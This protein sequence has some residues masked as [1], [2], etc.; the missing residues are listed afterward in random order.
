MGPDGPVAD[1]GDST[2]K[3]LGRARAPEGLK[4]YDSS[5]LPGGETSM[6]NGEVQMIAI[7]YRIVLAVII[8][9]VA[10]I[11]RILRSRR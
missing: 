1:C 9:I 4:D 10:A 3:G 11:F 6:Q 5:L 8:G 7:D 2:G